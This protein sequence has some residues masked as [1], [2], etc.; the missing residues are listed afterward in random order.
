MTTTK[1]IFYAVLGGGPRWIVEVEWSDGT[2]EQVEEFQRQSEAT[3]WITNQSEAW[4]RD[5]G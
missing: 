4:L 3:D 2:I 5:R 1:P